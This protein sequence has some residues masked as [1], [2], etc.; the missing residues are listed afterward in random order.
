MTGYISIPDYVEE[1][2]KPRQRKLY[3]MRWNPS[4]SS[5]TL[6]DFETD[7]Q[8]FKDYKPMDMNWSIRDYKE[9]VHKD[10]FIMCRVGGKDDG[11][12]WAGF[13]DHFPY[14]FEYDNGR[15][16]KTRY[17]DMSVLFMQR[18]EKTKIL[19]AEELTKNIPEI[20]WTHGHSG[21]LI[22]TVTAEK[23]AR[24]IGN[25]LLKID[26][27]EDFKFEEFSQKQYVISDFVGYLCPELKRELLSAGRIYDDERIDADA[28]VNELT[29]FIKKEDMASGKRLE[30][31]AMLREIGLQQC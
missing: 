16:G 15:L 20:D 29:I 14:Q 27:C 5:Y 4:I 13:L 17:I 26:D 22:D 2:L 10:L 25:E 7:F 11:V 12:V 8:K 30:E 18:T 24:Y 3:I 9:V 28:D 19:S 23:I 6:N 1:G 21:V 31:I